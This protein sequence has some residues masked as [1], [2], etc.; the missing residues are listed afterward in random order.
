VSLVSSNGLDGTFRCRAVTVLSV[1]PMTP[2][3]HSVYAR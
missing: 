3:A 1:E 2:G